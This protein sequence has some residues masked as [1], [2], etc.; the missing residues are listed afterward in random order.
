[1]PLFFAHPASAFNRLLA[2]THQTILPLRLAIF[3]TILSIPY[4]PVY[5]SHLEHDSYHLGIFPYMA[6]R[7]TIKYYGPIAV[8]FE[9]ALNKPIKLESQ[10]S[11]TDFTQALALHAYD[12]ALIQPF[13]Y[14]E[15]VEKQ[16]YIPLA[17]LS[18]PSDSPR[19][20]ANSSK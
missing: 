15:V 6:P 3:L 18:V 12:I 14:P 4:Q 11:F 5:G 16:G 1:M 2:V 9:H 13:D 17:R 19:G 8:D 20:S 7:Q 10:R